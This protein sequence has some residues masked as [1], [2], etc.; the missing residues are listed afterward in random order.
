MVALCECPAIPEHENEK[1][2]Q[3]AHSILTRAIESA[4]SFFD[5]FAKVRESRNAEETPTDHEQ[6]LLRAALMFAAAGLDAMVKQL[7]RDALGIVIDKD[8]GARSQFS[9]YVEKRLIRTSA[10]DVKYVARTLVSSNPREHLKK[11]LVRD[12]TGN[13]LQSKDQLLRV[14]A[15][16]AIRPEDISNDINKLK[17]VFDARNEI[18]HE[19]DVLLEQPTRNRRPRTFE[20][21]QDYT[22]F[23]LKAS[24]SFYISVEQKIVGAS[25]FQTGA[26]E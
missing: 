25:Q 26:D 8:K 22:S 13:S 7:V 5:A 17:T 12:L 14:A 21:M 1:A 4:Q 11:E 18:A 2:L 15:S 16:F 6:D 20:T 10:L 3:N 9:E 23:V 19:M 24:C